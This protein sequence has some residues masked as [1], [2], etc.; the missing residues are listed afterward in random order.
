MCVIVRCRK[1][2]GSLGR[3]IHSAILREECVDVHRIPRYSVFSLRIFPFPKHR[4]HKGDDLHKA[5]GSL[6][7][8]YCRMTCTSGMLAITGDESVPSSVSKLM[9]CQLSTLPPRTR[10]RVDPSIMNYYAAEVRGVYMR[11]I[12][13]AGFLGGEGTIAYVYEE[14]TSSEYHCGIMVVYQ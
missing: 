1:S 9:F 4:L 10:V 7:S 12:P 11:L 13:R 14:T 6:S 3:E 8:S 2:S 5:G